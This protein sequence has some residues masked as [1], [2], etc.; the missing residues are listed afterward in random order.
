MLIVLRYGARMDRSWQAQFRRVAGFNARIEQNVGGARLVQAFANE[1][2]ERA[3]FAVE[4]ASYRQEKQGA[5]RLM[6]M[7]M[8]LNY[9]GMR[10]VQIVVM[11]GGDVLHR[12]GRA[13][14]RGF[15]GVS[16]A[17]GVF[18]RPL[19]KIGSVIEIYPRGIA[20]FRRYNEFLA[21]DAG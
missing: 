1:D 9:L 15:R 5:Y 3:L 18:Y 6:A 4:N 21:V 12:A 14:D 16:A 13:F 17:G 7:S 11:L 10:L 20:G 8:T 19:D 2:H